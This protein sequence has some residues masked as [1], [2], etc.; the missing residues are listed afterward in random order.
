MNSRAV[1]AAAPCTPAAAAA[2]SNAGAPR[3]RKAADDAGEHVAGARGGELLA[4][5]GVDRG[6]ATGLGD[7]RARALQQHH[8]AAR[9]ASARAAA[10]R[11]V[12]DRLAGEP[13]VLGVVGREH[14]GASERGG[15]QRREVAAER[16]EPVGVEHE[17]GRGAAASTSR[18]EVGD[19]PR[20]ARARARPRRGGTGRADASRVG[21]RAD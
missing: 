21:Q 13:C 10:T 16:V 1:S 18:H 12:T 19:G 4:P 9:A 17:R 14:G 11:S 6:P 20:R 15:R 7:H 3:A 8:R 2:P 5:G